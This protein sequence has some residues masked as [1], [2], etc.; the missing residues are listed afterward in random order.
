MSIYNV[1]IAETIAKISAELSNPRITLSTLEFARLQPD[2]EAHPEE[3]A[4]LI[5]RLRDRL[6]KGAQT[7]R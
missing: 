7:D 4:G 3:R 1:W 6:R 5:A 2:S